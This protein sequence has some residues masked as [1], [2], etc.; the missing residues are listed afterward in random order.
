MK[1]TAMD[2]SIVPSNEVHDY[3][4]HTIVVEPT[5]CTVAEDYMVLPWQTFIANIGGLLG[6]FCG[7][8]LIGAILWMF[9]LSTTLRLRPRQKDE[10]DESS[11]ETCANG[12]NDNSG[13]W[14]TPES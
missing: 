14:S 7:F 4:E 8:S 3:A 6:M 5:L 11:Y 12:L 9:K 13:Q 1:F 10:H 2:L